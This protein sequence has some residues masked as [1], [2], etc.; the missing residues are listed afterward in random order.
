MIVDFKNEPTYF[1]GLNE[2]IIDA[3]KKT[4]I[5]LS[6]KASIK[7]L[8]KSLGLEDYSTAKTQNTIIP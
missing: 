4:S 1:L 3:E 2:R 7:A 5:F 6:Q 8:I